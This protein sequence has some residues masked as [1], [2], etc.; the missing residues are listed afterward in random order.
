MLS[1]FNS[2]WEQNQTRLCLELSEKKINDIEAHPLNGELTNLINGEGGSL[3]FFDNK[4]VVWCTLA[5][6]PLQLQKVVEQLQIW[7]LPSYGWQ[8]SGDGYK[9]PDQNGGPFQQSISN[10]SPNNYFRWQSSL[11]M[12]SLIENKLTTRYNL[13]G[14]RPE[15]K[16]RDRPSLYE[17]RTQFQTALTIGDRTL[18]EKAINMI[19]A[20]ELDKALNTQMMYI[21][22]WHHF[23]EFDRIKNCRN[24]SNLQAQPSLPGVINKCIREAIGEIATEP[25]PIKE[26]VFQVAEVEIENDWEQWFDFLNN[27]KDPESSLDW[28]KEKSAISVEELKPDQ[29]KSYSD[30]WDALFVNDE[31]KEKHKSLINEGLV[32]FLGDFIRE[33]EFPRTSFAGLYLSLL[34]LW[35]EMNAGIGIGR[36]EGH[37]LLELASALF[38]LNHEIDEAKKIVEEWWRARPVSAQLPFALDAIELLVNQHPDNEAA[39][40]LW[41]E[42]ADQAKRNPQQLLESEKILWRNAGDRIGIDDDTIHEYFPVEQDVEP[43]DLLISANLKT[44]AIVCMRERQARIASEMIKDRTGAK[45]LIVS[46]KVAGT[47]TGQACSC[48]VVL[49]VWMATTHAVFRAFDSFD[50]GQLCYVQ[51]TGSA[52]IV[53]ALERWC[54][55]RSN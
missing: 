40:N 54:K 48:D 50:R 13:E 5:P 7:I 35:G 43:E 53:R 26:A 36:E 4:K 1:Q 31:L 11:K 52:S 39:G 45:V 55:D 10:I 9:T 19:D 24:L 17:L 46:S 3:P 2:N 14:K 32:T 33:P 20:Y 6:N 37:V 29:I 15:R 27:Q 12:C 18:A 23:R 51:G 28:L 41:I 16:R 8:G 42:A 30:W 34:R 47:D 25:E 38:G 22:L 21:R 44:V 49:F